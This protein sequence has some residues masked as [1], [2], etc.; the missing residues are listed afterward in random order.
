MMK[1]NKLFCL[2][3]VSI[4]IVSLCACGNSGSESNDTNAEDTIPV[5][6]KISYMKDGAFIADVDTIREGIKADLDKTPDE[7]SYNNGSGGIHLRVEWPYGDGF[8]LVNKITFY[9]LGS[10]GSDE[11]EHIMK[12]DE[13]PEVAAILFD[14]AMLGTDS[15]NTTTALAAEKATRIL[16]I[17]DPVEFEGN[18]PDLQNTLLEMINNAASGVSSN[19]LLDAE[20][21]TI[22]PYKINVGVGLVDKNSTMVGV[23]LE[24]VPG[25]QEQ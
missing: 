23:Y 12:F 4:L 10:D 17:L 9:K 1:I 24:T 20:V 5:E 11:Y 14:T 16:R 13:T 2:M 19:Q 6:E 15:F 7:C 25:E 3:L 21:R 22:G 18:Q 8:V